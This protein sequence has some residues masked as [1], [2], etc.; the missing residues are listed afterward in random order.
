M[1]LKV[2][3]RIKELREV[4][5]MTQAELANRIGIASSTISSYE[6]NM[7]QP[8]LDMLI[9]LAAEFNVTTDYLLGINNKTVTVEI[10]GLNY[11]QNLTVNDMILF[12]KNQN[13]KVS[14]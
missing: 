3:T 8:S 6:N 1:N 9:K 4:K 5:K 14:N 13:A 12:Y 7:R 2:G 11:Q 10:T